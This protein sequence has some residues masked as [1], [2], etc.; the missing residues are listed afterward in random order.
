[1]EATA[2]ADGAVVQAGTPELSWTTNAEAAGYWLEI[3][4][5]ANFSGI[6]DSQFGLAEAHYAAAGLA[7]GGYYWRVAALDGFGLPGPKSAKRR[8]TLHP[9]ATPPYLTIEM[10]ADDAVLRQETVTV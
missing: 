8:F 4:A 10:P 9:D 1:P 7:A 6:V 5:D 2:P 3:A